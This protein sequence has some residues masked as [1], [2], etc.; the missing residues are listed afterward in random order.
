MTNRNRGIVQNQSSLYRFALPT[1]LVIF[2]GCAGLGQSPIRYVGDTTEVAELETPDGFNISPKELSEIIEAQDGLKIFMD[3]YYADE[4]N[5]YILNAFGL[6]NS[7]FTAR[8]HG[9]M[10]NGQTGEIYN[11]TTETW[12]PDPREQIDTPL[13]TSH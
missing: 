11:R 5:Y 7:R 2:V 8:T 12:E 6:F 3:Y 1:V 13:A 9:R 4:N 10:I